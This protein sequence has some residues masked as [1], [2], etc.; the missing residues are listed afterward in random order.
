MKIPLVPDV[1]NEETLREW[2][3]NV[4]L[5]LKDQKVDALDQTISSPP[6]QAEVQDM[7]DKIDEMVGKID[8]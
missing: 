8:S 2:M 1:V 5:Y 3:I 4:V 7:T 6:T